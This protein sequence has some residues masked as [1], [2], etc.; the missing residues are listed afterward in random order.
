MLEFVNTKHA[1][2]TLIAIAIPVNV[3]PEPQGKI[4]KPELYE[5]VFGN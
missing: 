4:I 3:F 5:L 2:Y 1:Y